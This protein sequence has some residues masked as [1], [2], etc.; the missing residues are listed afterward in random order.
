MIDVVLAEDHHLVREGLRSML[1]SDPDFEVVAE[2]GDGLCVLSLVDEHEP[3]I[4]V[5]DLLLPGLH[6]LE[7]L[8]RLQ[9][10]DVTTRAVVV[11]VHDH[12]L[13]IR[14]AL[15]SGASGYV[16]KNS[17][18]H[19]LKEAMRHVLTGS[20]YIDPTVSKEEIRIDQEGAGDEEA[21]W[22]RTVLGAR[23]HASLRD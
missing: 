6:G 5:L 12:E 15:R 11:S 9:G 8:K 3:D 20:R 17:P 7:I 16:V 13:Y 23:G 10:M 2:T 22:I 4:L 21:P 14:Q 19:I 18:V 1:E